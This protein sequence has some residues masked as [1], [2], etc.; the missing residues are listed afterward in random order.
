MDKTY[1]ERIAI[2]KDCLIAR[3]SKVDGTIRCDSTKYLSPDG[4]KVSYLPKA[5]WTRGCGCNQSIAASN[6]NKHCTAGKW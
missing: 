4:T 6:P 1:E 5:G 3:I 2:C